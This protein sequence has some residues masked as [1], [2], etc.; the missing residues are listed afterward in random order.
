MS[1]KSIDFF[2]SAQD[3]VLEE[4][5]LIGKI[6]PNLYYKSLC[7]QISNSTLQLEQY[8][9]AYP[10][11]QYNKQESIKVLD[12]NSNQEREFIPVLISQ[13][14]PKQ[15]KDKP[16]GIILEDYSYLQVKEILLYD[17]D[18]KDL[19]N[20]EYS[21]H[22]GV[23]DYDNK[24]ET[25]YFRYDREIIKRNPPRKKVNHFHAVLDEPH[26]NCNFINLEFVLKFLEDNWE[27]SRKSL[28]FINAI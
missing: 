13:P 27:S 4:L 2:I 20:F 12:K 26:Y 25:Y 24:I 28:Y 5:Q 15:K 14:H 3:V 21:Y 1:K 6:H 22:Y 9:H 23:W 7:M 8:D 16:S 17:V 18:T 11:L 10:I 19:Y